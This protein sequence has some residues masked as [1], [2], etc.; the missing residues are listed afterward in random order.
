MRRAVLHLH[1]YTYN[2]CC[3]FFFALVKLFEFV[4]G[5]S[6]VFC[7]IL[8]HVHG[9]GLCYVASVIAY[10]VCLHVSH[11][12]IRSSKVSVNL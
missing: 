7:S 5:Y 12:Y 11:I 2:T 1:S 10:T 9:L 3:Q 4:L 8:V 6:V